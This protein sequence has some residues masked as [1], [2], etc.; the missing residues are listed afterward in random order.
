MPSSRV[1]SNTDRTIVFTIPNRLTTAD[2]GEQDV[3]HHQGLSRFFW[4]LVMNASVV[5]SW[6]SG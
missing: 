4:S 2:S 1:R 5:C 6:A 3:E